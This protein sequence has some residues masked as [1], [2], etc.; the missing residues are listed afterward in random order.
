MYHRHK[1][2]DLKSRAH[3]QENTES[4]FLFLFFFSA[5]SYVACCIL[6]VPPHDRILSTHFWSSEVSSPFD[7]QSLA[8]YTWRIEQNLFR[9]GHSLSYPSSGHLD[10]PSSPL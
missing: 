2:L 9:Q 3:S 6:S 4:A 1:L 5:L 7:T 8:F 10:F